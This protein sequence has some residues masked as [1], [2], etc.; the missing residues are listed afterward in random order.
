MEQGE[1]V[2]M[3][4]KSPASEDVREN[5]PLPRHP[6]RTVLKGWVFTRQG[7]VSSM[8][9]KPQKPL[10]PLAFFPETTPALP[11]RSILV[12]CGDFPTGI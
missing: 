2:S 12:H 6:E 11:W 5:C 4:G 1:A 8:T 3:T 9:P 7:G 10:L